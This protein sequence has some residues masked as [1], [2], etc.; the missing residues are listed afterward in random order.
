M[1][2]GKIQPFF[3]VK[4]RR[5]RFRLL[6]IGPSRHYQLFL[7]NPDNPAQSIPYWRISNDGNLYE[8]PQLTT[9][10]KLA[11]AERADIIVDFSQLPQS[12][13]EIFLV[14]RA[15][16]TD[17]R[18]PTGNTLPMAQSPKLLKFIIRPGVVADPSRVPSTLR[19]LPCG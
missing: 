6:D 11:P 16:Q 1:V 17:G 10:V 8:K 14:N 15:E 9:N 13:T 12:T 7:T 19:A 18:G 5:Y 3:E 2:N 4:K